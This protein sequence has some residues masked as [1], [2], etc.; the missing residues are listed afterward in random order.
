MDSGHPGGL[1]WSWIL[2][3]IL[4]LQLLTYLQA[5]KTSKDEVIPI[6]LS[7]DSRLWFFSMQRKLRTSPVRGKEA[8]GVESMDRGSLRPNISWI[9]DQF[10]LSFSIHA[11]LVSKNFVRV[12]CIKFFAQLHR[13]MYPIFLR[14]ILI[15]FATKE[16]AGITASP[17]GW[18]RWVRGARSPQLSSY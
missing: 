10:R 11:L 18:D 7:L 14:L 9:S 8:P 1:P 16:V 6:Y 12:S 4:I 15:V 2:K 5:R 17:P 3:D 13:K